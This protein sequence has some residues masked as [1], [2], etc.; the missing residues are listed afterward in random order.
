MSILDHAARRL[1][2][3][4]AEQRAARYLQKRGLKILHRNFNCR[5]GEIDLIALDGDECLAFIEVRYRRSQRFGG[6]LA[7]V[8]ARK[9]TRIRRAASLFIS[10]QPRLALLACRF[11]VVAIETDADTEQWEITWIKNAFW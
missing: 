3:I 10:R 11:D 1:S 5:F 7:S 6:A 2:G 9:Q 8:T 4:H